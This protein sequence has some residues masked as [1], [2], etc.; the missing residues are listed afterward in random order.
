MASMDVTGDPRVLR[1]GQRLSQGLVPRDTFESQ[2]ADIVGMVSDLEPMILTD[3][4]ATVDEPMVA[5]VDRPVADRRDFDIALFSDRAAYRVDDLAVFTVATEEACFLTLINVDSA[6]TATV[7]FPNR[8]QQDNFVAAGVDLVVPP[9]DAGFQF[10]LGD[11]GTETV[12]AICS[13]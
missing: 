3:F 12:I 1:L 5:D 7:I 2:F 13:L 11:P 10:R 9:D 8:Y 6:G 4:I